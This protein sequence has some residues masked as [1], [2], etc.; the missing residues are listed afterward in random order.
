TDEELRLG[1]ALK[2]LKA[3]T[4]TPRGKLS[5]LW[6]ALRVNDDGRY[7]AM[8]E[9]MGLSNPG[10]F[11]EKLDRKLVIHGLQQLESPTQKGSVK[12]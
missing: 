3:S 4:A 1:K 5:T 9:R 11:R 6:Q 10:S 8:I 7:R 12:S 2:S